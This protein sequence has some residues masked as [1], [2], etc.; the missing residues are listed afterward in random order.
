MKRGKGLAAAALACGSFVIA[1]AF[2]GCSK[3]SG[4]NDMPCRNG[5]TVA[6][7][8]A[9]MGMNCG[10]V[11]CADIQGV[12]ASCGT[13]PSGTFC[14]GG[15]CAMPLVDLAACTPFCS[16]VDLA[17]TPASGDLAGCATPVITDF[18]PKSGKVGDHVELFGS[19]LMFG[20]TAPTITLNGLP[21]IFNF[22]DSGS[23]DA[24]IPAGAT[25]GKIHIHT[26][27]GDAD[28]ATAYQVM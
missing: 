6:Q 27:C 15:L 22:G 20:T 19:G 28:T 13:C 4:T 3:N 2:G 14:A 16:P 9:G 7:V 11:Q 17:A 23:V 5:M 1:A 21:L 24:T 12:S 10:T 25:T 18:N 8:C 26:D